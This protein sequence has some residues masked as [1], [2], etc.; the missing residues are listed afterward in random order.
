MTFNHGVVGSSPTALTNK[1]KYLD[2]IWLCRFADENSICTQRVHKLNEKPGAQTPW[3][4]AY[5][6]DDIP[7]AAELRSHHVDDPQFPLSLAVHRRRALGR[8]HD[9]VDILRTCV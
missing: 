8:S 1:I 3:G 6:G 7:A 9:S 5:T 2:L 4:G